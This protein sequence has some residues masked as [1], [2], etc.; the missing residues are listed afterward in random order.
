MKQIGRVSWYLELDAVDVHRRYLLKVLLRRCDS[1]RVHG[2]D[3][4]VTLAAAA[5][6]H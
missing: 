6:P 4:G 3:R 2:L 1:A 5:S